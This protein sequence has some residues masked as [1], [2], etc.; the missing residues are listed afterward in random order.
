MSLTLYYSGSEV[1][2]WRKLLA[3]QGVTDVGLSFVGLSRRTKF[4]RPWLIS[5]KFP[6]NQ[7]VFLDSGAYTINKSADKY[8]RADIEDLYEIYLSFVSVN[9]SRVEIVS[10]MDAIHL[11]QT[12]IER[13]RQ[14]LSEIAGGKFLPIWHVESGMPELERLAATYGRVGVPQASVGGRDIAVTLNRLAR[15][16]VRLHGVAMTQVKLMESVVWDSVASTSWLSPAQFGDSQIWTGHELKRYPRAYKQQGRKRHRQHL[17]RQGFDTAL[18]EGDNVAEVL[19]VALWS[20]RQL[21][22]HINARGRHVVGMSLNEHDP[23][24]AENDTEVVRYQLPETRNEI[25]TVDPRAD[26]EREL[27]PGLRLRQV[28]RSEVGKDGETI[29]NTINLPGV[30]AA[31]LR[32]C[33]SCYVS[34]YCRAMRPGAGCA[35]EIPIEIKTPE[36]KAAADDAIRAIR[37]QRIA[38]MSMV[39]QLEGGY[40]DPNLTKELDAW[41]RTRAKERSEDADTLSINIKASSKHRAEGGVLNRL[42][43]RDPTDSPKEL[44]APVHSD[45]VFEEAGIVEAEV[46]E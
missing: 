19:K 29:E 42:F 23:V 45:R 12:W 26:G 20:W 33:D 27:L 11:G 21:V 15:Q 24:S 18:Y 16:G 4:K 43:G 14:E 3:E 44:P 1:H 34:S 30:Q 46:V 39:E 5:D 28:T 8:Q 10:E 13:Q 32:Q 7:R 22:D 37:F 38:F 36:Q 2:G 17:Q 41:D 35:Y 25:A 9:I 6:S 40:A 31:S